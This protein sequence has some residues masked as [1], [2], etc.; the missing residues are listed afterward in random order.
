LTASAVVASDDLERLLAPRDGVVLERPHAAGPPSP[1]GGPG[2][3]DS[4]DVRSA[5]GTYHFDLEAGPLSEYHRTIVVAPAPEPGFVAVDQEVGFTVGV[6]Y[7][8]WLFVLPLRANLGGVEPSGR[9]PWWAPPQRLGYPAAVTLAALCALSVL[10]G[11]LG[12]LLPTVMTYAGRD[13]GV[14]SGGQGIALGI[15]QVNAVLALALLA[16]AD[17]RGRRRLIL[18]CTV[19]GA[20]LTAL[21][22]LSPSLSVL[23]AT[24]VVAASL[25]TALDVLLGIMAVEEMPPGSRAW[26]LALIAMSF[27]LGGGVALAVLPLA[28]I[29]PDGWRWLFALAVLVIP[30]VIS[31]ARHLPESTRWRHDV[32]PP[33]PPAL[34]AAPVTGDGDAGGNGWGRRYGL[35]GLTA[36]QRR[37]LLIL[38]A[39]ALL[40]A[41]FD[42]PSGQ[43]QNQYL[44]T[45][46]HWSATRISLADQVAGTVGGVGTIFGGR[47]ADTHGRRPVAA[48]A[49]GLGTAVTLLE[50]FTHG[51]ALYGWMTAGSVLGYAVVPALAVYGAELFPSSL[52]GR[53]GGILTILA[54]AGGLVGLAATGLLADLIGT[55]G[56]ALA[57]MAIGPLALIVLIIRAYP[58]TAGRRLED[59]N[60]V[61]DVVE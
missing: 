43:L 6:P 57:I 15:V 35:G 5:Y 54:A 14:G 19:G 23:T 55:I 12:D 20:V 44:R 38:G 48:I 13:F 36:I 61:T 11:Y 22:A 28:G 34:G 47:L 41:L 24:Q 56:P 7:V 4:S 9:S 25:V 51:P 29:G 40:F 18:A 46:R 17:R 45:Q 16:R 2:D 37:R 49:I 52:R 32:G 27:G 3:R 1:D 39:G 26:A 21:G 33:L 42:A 10:A 31:C 30:A 8:S 58:E 59:L 60:P 50:Y 53:A